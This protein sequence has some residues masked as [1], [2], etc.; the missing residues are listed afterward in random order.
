MA[1]EHTDRG[2]IEGKSFFLILL[3]QLPPVLKKELEISS[4]CH[5]WLSFDI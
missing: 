3:Q 2:K 1:T 4:D 5:M